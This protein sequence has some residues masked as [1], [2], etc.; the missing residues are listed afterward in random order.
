MGEEK[1]NNIFIGFLIGF[2]ICLGII[3]LM[4]ED[5]RTPSEKLGDCLRACEK[6]GEL[7]PYSWVEECKNACIRE[8]H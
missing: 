5:N 1:N 8:I 6:E 4:R 2:F 3:W 7:R